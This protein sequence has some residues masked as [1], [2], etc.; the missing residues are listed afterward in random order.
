MPTRAITP[1][2][3]ALVVLVLLVWAAPLDGQTK[4]VHVSRYTVEDGL[5]QNYVTAICQDRTGY[6]WVGTSRG[7]QRFD[8][9]T[10]VPYTALDADAPPELSRRIDHLSVDANGRLWVMTQQAMF[11][12]EPG[13]GPLTRV[14]AGAP[15]V[16]DSAGVLRFVAGPGQLGSVDWNSVAP[17]LTLSRSDTLPD[18]CR[19]VATTADNRFLWV[20]PHDGQVGG[21]IRIDVTTGETRAFP[22]HAITGVQVIREDGHGTIW[23]GGFGGIAVL[24]AGSERFRVLYAFSGREVGDIESDGAG[25]FIVATDRGL[26]Q[27]DAGGRI[28]ERWVAPETDDNTPLLVRNMIADREGGWWVAT[29]A[30]GLL[31][32]DPTPTV[33]E[34]VSSSSIRS[35]SPVSDFVMAV[36]EKSDR[37]LW[38]GTMSGS[39]HHLGEGWVELERIVLSAASTD[40][41]PAGAVWAIEEHDAGELW[42]GTSNGLCLASPAAPATGPCYAPQNSGLVADIA[43]APDGWFWLAIGGSGVASFHPPTRS[44]GFVTPH[45][46]WTIMAHFDE[47]QQ[48]LWFGGTALH[49]V[50]V[51]DGQ[52]LEPPRTVITESAVD[53]S[54]YDLRRDRRGVLWLA[55]HHGLQRWDSVAQRFAIVD[56]P[57][58][59]NTTVFSVVEDGGGRLWLGTSH[60][61]VEYSPI[62][63]IARRYRAQDGIRSGEFNRRAALRRSNGELVFG[64]LHGLTL[65]RPERVNAPRAPAPL[66]FTRWQ[67][68]TADGPTEGYPTGDDALELRRGDRA[69]TLEFAAL[70]FA[71]G[72]ARHYRYRLDGLNS[73][74]IET[75]NHAVTYPTPRPGRYTFRVQ[76]AGGSEGTW[77]EPGA[78]FALH[79]VPPLW[80]TAWFRVLLLT[81]LLFGLWL[82]HRLRLRQVIATERLRL[83]IARDL[84]D[85]I[86]AGLSSIALL[87]DAAAAL[88]MSERTHLDRIGRSAR[89]MVADLRDIVW[90][91]DPE[92][93]RVHDVVTRMQDVAGDLLRGVHVGF[94]A[95]PTDELNA[96]IGMPARRDLLRM[97]KEMLHNIARHA[98]AQRVD[99]RLTVHGDV[100][101]LII[102]DDG[103]GFDPD[104]VRAGTGLRSMRERAARLGG[105]LH[106]DA[107]A[108]GGCMITLTLRTT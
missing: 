89:D 19:A 9:Y 55:S 34:H 28:V 39:A 47:A 98:H 49:R 37:T 22:L 30:A 52:F 71:S 13:R 54:F 62:S 6:I 79:V 17:R 50:R 75:S 36:H 90:A 27:V 21:V 5:A 96:R 18:C 48:E 46:P 31:R 53:A 70:A 26:A 95:P 59:R 83:R 45:P 42:V 16:P 24:D 66:V 103:V 82:L 65:F 11:Y 101:H 80:S 100:V 40:G 3:P 86:G 14:A 92:G 23:V 32:Y 44:F 69:F 99:I 4:T 81:L 102:T 93:D 41:Q 91:I 51:A 73:D 2:A 12:G 38:T 108:G 77:A 78:A 84:H 105:H 68:V 94:I 15:A 87:S 35:A 43:R 97:Y 76:L 8:G 74:W 20:A 88:D 67:K 25:G 33:F 1:C 64:G 106:I 61:L 10:F 57:V 85:E 72:P 58:L 29:M 56:V 107:R 63:G 7:L 60:G 104:A